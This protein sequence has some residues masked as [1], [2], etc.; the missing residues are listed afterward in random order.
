MID[1]HETHVQDII[2]ER[3]MY[4]ERA[5][6]AAEEFVGLKMREEDLIKLVVTLRQ[7]LIVKKI[8]KNELMT[9]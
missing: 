8:E 6:M 7:Q 9:K 5:F 3:S 2:D 1:H 4:R